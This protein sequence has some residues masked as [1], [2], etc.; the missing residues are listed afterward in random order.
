M[1]LDIL[2][3]AMHQD[4][5]EEL[6]EKLKIRGN[7]VLVNQCGRDAV[8]TIYEEPLPGSASGSSESGAR[9][10]HYI[11]TTERGLSRSR[12][13]A[14]SYSEGDICALCDDDVQY[15]DNYESLILQSYGEHPEA[16]VIVFFVK[17]EEKP[18]PYYESPRYLHYVTSMKAGSPEITFRRKSLSGIH[19]PEMFGAG[20]RFG[21][22]EESILLYAC[23]KRGL[24]ILYLP[25]QIAELLPSKSTWF[26]GYTDT[27]FRDKGAA[28]GAMGATAGIWP[29]LLELQFLLRKYARYRQENTFRSAWKHMRLGQKEYERQRIFLIGDYHSP[30]GP[31]RVTRQLLMHLPTDTLYVKSRGKAGQALEIFRKSQKAGIVLC[32]GLSRQ[33]LLGI[34][35]A[36]RKG[37]KSA[38]LMH[39][40]VVYENEINKGNELREGEN[41]SNQKA[42]LEEAILQEA[43]CILAVSQ[44]F[45][46]WIKARYPKYAPKTACTPNGVELEELKESLEIRDFIDGKQEVRES[47]GFTEKKLQILSL[48]GGV[49]EKNML[50]LCRAVESWNQKHG[51]QIRLLIAGADGRDTEEIQTYA[52]VE[53]LGSLPH[54][55]VLKLFRE[56]RIYVQNS[57][58][59][60][61][62]LAILEA[63]LWGCDCLIS[64]NVGALSELACEEY[65]VIRDVEDGEEIERKLGLLLEGRK[66]NQRL[67]DSLDLRRLE[68]GQRALELERILWKVLGINERCK[69]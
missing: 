68:A 30:N 4:G 22:G 61:F 26:R 69:E 24:K 50:P 59:E 42:L 7:C 9:R 16:D 66:N 39:G 58:L 25:L 28:F 32:S 48:G 21:M 33:C 67:R 41:S 20:S 54:G 55:Q 46:S 6:L 35:A 8:Q 23:L 52:C 40:C 60:T 63:V 15:V 10:I 18:R 2:I 29:S 65:D 47:Q 38:Y 34:R 19:F 56:S 3:S 49:P 64:Q 57:Y 11:E 43:D 51:E 37:R 62:G 17:G 1:K 44:S 53:Y 31:G 36:S 12:N 13:M 14:L 27:F 45:C 5:Y